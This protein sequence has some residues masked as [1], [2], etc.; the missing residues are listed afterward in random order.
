MNLFIGSNILTTQA[1]I[2]NNTYLNNVEFLLLSTLS[3]YGFDESIFWYKLQYTINYNDTDFTGDVYV[4]S[5]EIATE[6]AD[7]GSMIIDSEG[8]Q[9]L[10]NCFGDWVESSEIEGVIG[11]VDQDGSLNVLDIVI[12]IQYIFE[13]TQFNECQFNIADISDDG[14]VNIYD[15]ILLVN[16]LIYDN[17]NEPDAQ[18]DLNPNNN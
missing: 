12:I 9:Y 4:S 6:Y 13:E 8:N 14:V 17:C 5:F 2:E 18:N 16:C 11:D 3:D 1:V 15:I 7:E 10:Q